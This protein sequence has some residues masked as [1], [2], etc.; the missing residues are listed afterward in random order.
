[1]G[2]AAADGR[3]PFPKTWPRVR[4][5]AGSSEI[6]GCGE[7]DGTIRGRN[8]TSNATPPLIIPV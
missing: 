2:G 5:K 3:A 6:S 1:M 4:P 7:A 8:S